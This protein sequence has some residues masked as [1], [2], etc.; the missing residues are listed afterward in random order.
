MWRK[1]EEM[2]K[3][4]V[5]SIIGFVGV[6]VFFGLLKTNNPLMIVGLFVSSVLLVFSA[7][8]IGGVTEWNVKSVSILFVLTGV[9]MMPTFAIFVLFPSIRILYKKKEV[10]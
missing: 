3:Y 10:V 2:K 5:S 7:M 4:A 8:K 9:S 6:L 1:G